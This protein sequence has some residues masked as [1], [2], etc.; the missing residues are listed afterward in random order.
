VP[1]TKPSQA[2]A[3]TGPLVPIILMSRLGLGPAAGRS[4]D[5]LAV[6]QGLLELG[7]AGIGDLR[8]AEIQ[9]M[10]FA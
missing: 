10:E 8:L 7:D 9:F 3:R 4:A 5:D 2:A 6:G 1:F